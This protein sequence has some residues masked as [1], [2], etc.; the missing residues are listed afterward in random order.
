MNAKKI[1]YAVKNRALTKKERKYIYALSKRTMEDSYG[2]EDSYIWFEIYC[3]LNKR[4]VD[5]FFRRDTATLECRKELM[6]RS[7][8]YLSS[9]KPKIP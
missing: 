2:T 7:A 9:N 1:I 8:N 4:T 5:C 6:K 3:A